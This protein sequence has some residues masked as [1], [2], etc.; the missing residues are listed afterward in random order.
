MQRTMRTLLSAAGLV[1]L[2]AALAWAA[3]VMSVQVRAGQLRDKPGFLSKVV[4]ELE[5]GDQVDLTGE[6]GD[7]RQVKSLGDGR[8]GWMHFSALTER[9]IVLNPTDKDVAAAADSD[10]LALAGKGFNKQVEDQYKR[11]TRLDYAKVDEM[12][13]IVVPQKYIR[14]FLRV[15]ELGGDR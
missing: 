14:E 13:K 4:G 1:V 12:E 10:E 5:Y 9:E 8:A 3:Q 15:G 2:A 7:W 11:Q 6:Q